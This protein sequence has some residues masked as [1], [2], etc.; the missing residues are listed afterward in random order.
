[1]GERRESENFGDETVKIDWR[2]GL[3]GDTRRVESITD[4]EASCFGT[5]PGDQVIEQR[6]EKG[7]KEVGRHPRAVYHV[8]RISF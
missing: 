4:G 8:A 1:M 6:E 7:E 5:Q 3:E 2:G